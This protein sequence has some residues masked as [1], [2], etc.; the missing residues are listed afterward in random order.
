MPAPFA[1]T[2]AV[3]DN[4][5]IVV[6]GASLASLAANALTN[7]GV[8]VVGRQGG[9]LIDDQRGATWATGSV[10][11]STAGA[12]VLAVRLTDQPIGD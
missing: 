6:K 12:D 8:D 9:S 11:L 10:T 5:D 7:V 4:E 2:P 3:T 1:Y